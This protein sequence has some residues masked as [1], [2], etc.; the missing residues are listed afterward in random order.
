M[1]CPVGSSESVDAA[2]WAASLAGIEGSQARVL[3]VGSSVII[4]LGPGGVVARVGGLT[5]AV[6]DVAAHHEREVA[7]ARWLAAVEAPVVEPW[8]P[9]GPFIDA[10]MRVKPQS[11]RGSFPQRSTTWAVSP[12]RFCGFSLLSR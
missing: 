3:Y 11:P 2:V 4:D 9:A 8:E 5:A 10:D 1:N 6:R 12:F 7:V